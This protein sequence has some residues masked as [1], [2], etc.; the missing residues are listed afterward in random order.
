LQAQLLAGEYRLRANARFTIDGSTIELLSSLDALV[1]KAVALV[2]SEQIK[3]YFWLFR[4]SC[5]NIVV[6]VS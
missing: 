4:N 5:G 3:G 1:L 6:K 2:L